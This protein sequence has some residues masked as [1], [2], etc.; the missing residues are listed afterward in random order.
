MQCVY[1]DFYKLSSEYFMAKSSSN[2]SLVENLDHLL[3]Q[4][5]YVF[6]YFV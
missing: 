4:R 6:I 3:V 2:N 5:L 1:F